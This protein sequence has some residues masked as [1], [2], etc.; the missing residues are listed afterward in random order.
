MPRILL[1]TMLPKASTRNEDHG[2]KAEAWP[3]IVDASCNGGQFIVRVDLH[4]NLLKRKAVHGCRNVRDCWVYI[5]VVVLHQLR[6]D[7]RSASINKNLMF[8]R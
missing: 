8:E 3:R 1:L 4:K 5:I 7:W 2:T 6:P